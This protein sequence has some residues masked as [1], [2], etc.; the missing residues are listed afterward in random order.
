MQTINPIES[1]VIALPEQEPRQ[2]RFWFDEFDAQ[3]RDRTLTADINNG[4]IDSLTGE[5]LAQY[6]ANQYKKI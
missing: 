6:G 3:N 1:E 2:F 4:K 5:T